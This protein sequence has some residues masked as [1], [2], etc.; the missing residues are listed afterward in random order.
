MVVFLLI[1]LIDNLSISLS[2]T[3][4]VTSSNQ[5]ATKRS[6]EFG[7]LVRRFAFPPGTF[8]IFTPEITLPAWREYQ[9]VSK[10]TS[11]KR[12]HDHR[13]CEFDSGTN[14]FSKEASEEEDVGAFKNSAIQ[15]ASPFYGDKLETF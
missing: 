14:A 8:I 11:D 1:I 4:N 10:K 9:K 6:W 12:L 5:E 15:I 2:I 7:G 3:T 13:I